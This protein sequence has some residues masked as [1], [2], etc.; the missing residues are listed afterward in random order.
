MNSAILSIGTHQIKI[1]SFFK[2]IGG[3]PEFKSVIR[4]KDLTNIGI[5]ISASWFG[6]R[7][8]RP[9]PSFVG[10]LQIASSQQRKQLQRQEQRLSNAAPS[11]DD[12]GGLLRLITEQKA[13]IKEADG[14]L[15]GLQDA[16][17]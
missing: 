10:K 17:R 9:Q 13:I 12:C 4:N 14:K 5:G 11:K 8:S 15:K 1:P 3:Q 2:E 16:A 6:D 7:F